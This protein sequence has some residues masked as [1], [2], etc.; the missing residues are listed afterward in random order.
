[1]TDLLKKLLLILIVFAL[2]TCIVFIVLI[3]RLEKNNSSQAITENNTIE[4]TTVENKITEENKE[5]D[6]KQYD[7]PVY[8]MLDFD[9]R[10]ILSVGQ[11]KPEM[12]SVYSLAYARAILDNNYKANPKDYWRN[13]AVWNLA[14]Y[15]DIAFDD[16]LKIV[17]QRAY[18]E[19]DNGR[20]TILYVSGLYA[21]GITPEPQE[22]T[23]YEHFVIILGYRIDADY[24]NLKPSDFYCA[25]AASGYSYVQEGYVPWVIL[26]D[27][28]P[29][30]MSGEY[31][32]FASSN[33]NKSVKTCLAFADTIK[34]NE[35]LSKPLAPNYID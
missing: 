30:K 32:L 22:R 12:C 27:D 4:N 25:D 23:S 7:Q 34:W 18:D 28:S 8:K 3:T 35:D 17:L 1:M 5:I 21:H 33:K 2:I 24:K 19:I 14:E 31:A 6:I 15:D 16:P 29:E 9:R 11:Q 26:T 13:E 20:P 10:L